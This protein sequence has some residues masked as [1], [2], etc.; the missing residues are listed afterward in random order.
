MRT[1]SAIPIFNKGLLEDE[2]FLTLLPGL[3]N[4]QWAG[5][6]C[7]Q[8]SSSEKGGGFNVREENPDEARFY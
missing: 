6:F 1:I 5:Y 2:V 3:S 4:L 8:G 7:I